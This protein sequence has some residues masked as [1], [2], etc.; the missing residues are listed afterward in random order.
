MFIKP[1]GLKEA[2]DIDGCCLK[3]DAPPDHHLR[4]CE[5]RDAEAESTLGCCFDSSLKIEASMECC[6]KRSSDS[7]ALM[8]ARDWMRVARCDHALWRAIE[9]ASRRRSPLQLLFDHCAEGSTPVLIEPLHRLFEARFAGGRLSTSHRARDLCLI[10]TLISSFKTVLHPA[11][12]AL[13]QKNAFI[14]L[15][16]FTFLQSSLHSGW[17]LL[18]LNAFV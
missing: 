13:P 4:L 5:S 12:G 16:G 2:S 10:S 18:V 1:I 15:F 9:P 17:G 3:P 6:L 7:G 8:V 14:V 11:F